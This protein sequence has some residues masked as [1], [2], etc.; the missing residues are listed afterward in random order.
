MTWG[1]SWRVP[2]LGKGWGSPELELGGL[3]P[4]PGELSG[5][6]CSARAV[7]ACDPC[8]EP[9]Q[10]FPGDV[11]PSWGFKAAVC[12]ASAPLRFPG[13]APG[14]RAVLFAALPVRDME[15]E[16]VL[17]VGSAPGLWKCKVTSSQSPSVTGA[18]L[19]WAPGWAA[20]AKLRPSVPL[21]A[22]SLLEAPGEQRTSL[23]LSC[24]EP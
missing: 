6:L 10:S 12:S 7:V 1:E 13:T 5:S 23:W 18:G 19:R 8:V 24:N 16:V 4:A 3:R 20:P 2:P 15:S 14:S 11:C 17:L 22:R 9:L 21:A